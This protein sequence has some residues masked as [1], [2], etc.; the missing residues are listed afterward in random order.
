MIQSVPVEIASEVEKALKG[1]KSL[2]KEN[3]QFKLK[4]SLNG[5]VMMAQPRFLDI[6]KKREERR[7]L[8]LVSKTFTIAKTTFATSKLPSEVKIGW[9]AHELG[10]IMDYQKLSTQKLLRFGFLYLFSR[11]FM[12]KAELRADTYAVKAGYGTYLIRTKN[13]ILSHTELPESYKNKIRKYYPSPDQILEIDRDLR[14]VSE[15]D[16]EP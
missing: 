14:K 13:F 8:V 3:I 4:K 12:R 11:S 10:H 16:Q 1:F 5:S 7:Y 9:F 15:I 2:K 6:F